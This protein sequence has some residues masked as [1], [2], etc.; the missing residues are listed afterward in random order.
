MKIFEIENRQVYDFHW[1]GDREGYVATLNG[2]ELGFH[3]A[4]STWDR[5]DAQKAA[6]NQLVKHRMDKHSKQAQDWQMNAPLTN[7]EKEWIA[8][9][10]KLIA[11]VRNKTE[12]FSD[13][14]LARYN[15]LAEVVRKSIINGTHPEASYRS[16]TNRT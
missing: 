15:G 1:D 11:T 12:D 16:F 6:K 5:S 7:L 3:K 4:V 14:E 8:L 2:E 9:D 13:K 10:K